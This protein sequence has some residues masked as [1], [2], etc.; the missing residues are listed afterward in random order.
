MKKIDRKFVFLLL[1]LCVV[2]LVFTIPIHPDFHKDTSWEEMNRQFTSSSIQVPSQTSQYLAD[3]D[4]AFL[5]DGRGIGA[6]I[7]GYTISSEL[8]VLGSDT[9][10]TISCEPISQDSILGQQP[11]E[12]VIRSQ[13]KNNV[14]YQFEKENYLY[15]CEISFLSSVDDHTEFIQQVD[16]ILEEIVD[17]FAL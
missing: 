17:E 6:G 4:Y 12:G 14:C 16:C 15:C 5:L 9:H 10:C 3:T 7:I 13:Y 8:N 1:A 11:N 2:G